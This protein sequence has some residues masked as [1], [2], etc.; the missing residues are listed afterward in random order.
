VV[1]RTK[2]SLVAEGTISIFAKMN[3]AAGMVT[4]VDYKWMKTQ[5]GQ[6]VPATADEIAVTIGSDGGFM[7]VHVQPSYANQLELKIPADPPSGSLPWTST[8]FAPSAVCG[9]AISFDDKLGLRHFIGGA[10]P[11]PGVTCTP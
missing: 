8:P 2:A 10:D 11:N 3:T 9:L 6:W 7:S 1:T 5:A 4:S